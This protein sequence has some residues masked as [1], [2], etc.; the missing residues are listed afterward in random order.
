M[1]PRAGLDQVAKRKIPC[2]CRE[3]NS[4]HAARSLV[5]I[6]TELPQVKVLVNQLKYKNKKTNLLFLK[7]AAGDHFQLLA[8]SVPFVLHSVFRTG[9]KVDLAL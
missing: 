4:S 6:L 8:F 7:A 3:S 5:T 2:L 9:G 1:G